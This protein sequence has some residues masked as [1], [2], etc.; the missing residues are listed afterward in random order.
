VRQ[1]SADFN[2]ALGWR[3]FLD[4]LLGLQFMHVSARVMHRD[5]KSANVLVV[6]RETGRVKLSDFGLAKI[7]TSSRSSATGAGGVAGTVSWSAPEVLKRWPRHSFAADVYSAGMVLYEIVSCEA[8]FAGRDV[9]DIRS[10]VEAG[11]RPRLPELCPDQA[12]S[13]VE[14]LWEHYPEKRLPLRDAIVEVEALLAAATVAHE[15]SP[16]NVEVEALLAPA[17]VAH[18]PSPQN[19]RAAADARDPS[20]PSLGFSSEPSRRAWDA[21]VEA[22]DRDRRMQPEPD[23]EKARRINQALQTDQDLLLR[24]ITENIGFADGR[25]TAAVVVFRSLLHWR[26]FESERTQLFDHIIQT[27]HGAIE[28]KEENNEV[29]AYWLSNTSTLLCFLQRTLK[30][31][32]N[33]SAQTRR[34]SSTGIFKRLGMGSRFRSLPSQEAGGGAGGDKTGIPGVRQVEAKYPALLF[35]QQLTAFVEK[36]YGMLRDNVKKEITPQLGQ[37][38]QA[39]KRAGGAAERRTTRSPSAHGPTLSTH[40]RTILEALEKLSEVMRQNHVPSFLVRKFFT[41]VFSF[42]NVQLF[43]SLLLRRECCSFSNGE[44]V[45]TGLAELENWLYDAGEESV[46]AATEE[47]RFIRQA[48]TL[49]V[50]HQKPKK[51]LNEITNDLCPVLTIQQLYRIS[52]MYWDDKYGTETV[53]QDVLIAMKQKMMEESSSSM[54]NSFL[55]DDDS[56]I[57]FTAEEVSSN[58]GEVEHLSD[59]V[60]LPPILRD[61]QTFAFLKASLV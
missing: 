45:K 36:I 27:M 2:E 54:S 57:P 25:P 50:I 58:A 43:N 48:V 51:T 46:G 20:S 40:W 8:P 16:Q 61:A 49:L 15:P 13:L 34:R 3:C 11:D 1:G 17:T 7:K 59:E 35:K 52:T 24:C 4:V 42:I 9:W 6:S 37:C 31:T 21:S 19:G 41:Q 38:I 10:A 56:S 53:S 22:A 28:G 32:S 26:A 30:S 18:E 5:L 23:A 39:P 29:L 44:Y 12:R 14:R 55:L 60:P 47:L 33:A